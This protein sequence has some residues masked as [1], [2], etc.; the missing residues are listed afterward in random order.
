MA[1]VGLQGA[2]A[3]SLWNWA[4]VLRGQHGGFW[5]AHVFL[6]RLSHINTRFKEK[7]NH[8]PIGGQSHQGGFQEELRPKLVL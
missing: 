7:L 2:Y 5:V 6:W 8:E 3:I 4:T 1:T